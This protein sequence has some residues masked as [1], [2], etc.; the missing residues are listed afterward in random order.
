MVILDCQLTHQKWFY[1]S[2]GNIR[3]SFKLVLCS[4]AVIRKNG[5]KRETICASVLV[6]VNLHC[7]SVKL[8]E[9]ITEFCVLSTNFSPNWLWEF[10]SFSSP[11]KLYLQDLLKNLVFPNGW[12]WLVYFYSLWR[13]S[14]L[15]GF[16]RVKELEFITLWN[17]HSWTTRER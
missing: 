14:V 3:R 16:K 11:T 7:F 4:L 10:F 12:M 15:F 5:T 6:N 13:F 2:L 9:L 17:I 1:P 8:K